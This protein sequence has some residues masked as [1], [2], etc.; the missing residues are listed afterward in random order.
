[1]NILRVKMINKKPTLVFCLLMD[2]LGSAT[3]LLPTFG[4]W[5]DVL[6]A[7][8]SAFIFYW[9]FGGKVGRIGSL[10][11]FTEEILPFTDL[12]P[13]FTLGYLF[14]RFYKK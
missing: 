10:I 3:Y 8:L 13:T 5:F 12:V 4:E 14:N 2:A 9:S 11:N 1:M 6:W 7:P